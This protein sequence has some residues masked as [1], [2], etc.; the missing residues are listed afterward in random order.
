MP[1][2]LRAHVFSRRLST[3]KDAFFE[4]TNGMVLAPTAEDIIVGAPQNVLPLRLFQIQ[5]KF[6]NEVRPSKG[7]TRSFEF[8]MKDGYTLHKSRPPLLHFV[9]KVLIAYRLMLASFGINIA[10]AM[11]VGSDIGGRHSF[12][13][14]AGSAD[15]CGTE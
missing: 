15:N 1:C 6:R 2:A 3:S 9:K 7:L 8:V 4:T 12:E 11:A 13:L 14:L 10:I 5:L